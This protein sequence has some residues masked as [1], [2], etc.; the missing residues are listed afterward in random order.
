MPFFLRLLFFVLNR[1][2]CVQ[3][4]IEMALEI[5]QKAE[6]LR[7]NANSVASGCLWS[8]FCSFFSVFLIRSNHT[9]TSSATKQISVQCMLHVLLLCC[10]CCCYVV[11]FYYYFFLL[12]LHLTLIPKL[13]LPS[14]P[15]PSSL[16]LLLQH[17]TWACVCCHSFDR[18]E[19]PHVYEW[20]YETGRALV[21][22]LSVYMYFDSLFFL[23]IKL[24]SLLLFCF[25]EK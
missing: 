21:R 18:I 7:A 8:N 13:L 9:L 24:F 16:L 14:T 25:F 15:P 4:H 17:T 1:V 6:L 3:L 22:S 10:C 12:P 19:R 11:L 20:T 2:H 23:F 5:C